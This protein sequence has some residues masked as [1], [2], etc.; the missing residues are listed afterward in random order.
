MFVKRWDMKFRFFHIYM[1]NITAWTINNRN[2]LT[3]MPDFGRSQKIF[4]LRVFKRWTFIF[5]VLHASCVLNKFFMV[6][7]WGVFAFQF[8]RFFTSLQLRATNFNF[9]VKRTISTC[10][11]RPIWKWEILV[12]IDTLK[13]LSLEENHWERSRKIVS[14]IHFARRM[15]GEKERK[16]VRVREVK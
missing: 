16:R 6:F 2:C 7:S 12:E 13:F 15:T 11:A 1:R 9:V 8:H 4:D 5:C 10:C 3:W 14:I